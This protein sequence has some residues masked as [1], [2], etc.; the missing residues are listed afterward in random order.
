MADKAA[1]GNQPVASSPKR[2]KAKIQGRRVN[3]SKVSGLPGL[4]SRL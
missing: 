4:R 3:T 1:S 2:S